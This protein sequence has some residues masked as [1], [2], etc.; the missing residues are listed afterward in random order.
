MCV[1]VCVPPFRFC[2]KPFELFGRVRQTFR[3]LIPSVFVIPFSFFFFGGGPVRVCVYAKSHWFSLGLIFFSF[4]PSV[5]FFS[6][7]FIVL[8]LCVC[9]CLLQTYAC[10]SLSL[11]LCGLCVSVFN[12]YFFFTPLFVHLRVNSV[13]YLSFFHFL[14]SFLS[15]SPCPFSCIHARG[16]KC[17]HVHICTNND[18]TKTNDVVGLVPT[19]SSPR[20]FSKNQRLKR[21]C[22]FSAREWEGKL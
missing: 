17:T 19:S 2:V 1:C 11:S 18:N 4:F 15:P 10:V 8:Y 7:W 20:T 3:S 14:T 12:M 6:F 21:L 5:P 16:I 13:F 22:G 9:V